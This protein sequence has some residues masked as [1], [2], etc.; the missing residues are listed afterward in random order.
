MAEFAFERGQS[1]AD[2]AQA[3]G[4]GQLAETSWQRTAANR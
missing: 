1:A 4:I 2:L 3:L